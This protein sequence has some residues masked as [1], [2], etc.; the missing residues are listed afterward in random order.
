[1]AGRKKDPVR[2][3]ATRNDILEKSYA[4][5]TEKTIEA[6][7]MIEI[8]KACGCG[9]TT[10]YRY[11]STKPALAVAV[12][13]RRFELLLAENQR[14]RLSAGF[15]GMTAAEVFAFYLDTFLVLYRDHRDALRFNQ[16]FNIYLRKERIDGETIGPYRELIRGITGQFHIIYEKAARD[17]TVRTDVS[18]EKA[19][20]TTL[21]LMLAA[22]TRYAVGLAYQPESEAE[23]LEELETLKRSLL[24]EYISNAECGTKRWMR[25]FLYWYHLPYTKMG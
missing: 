25:G 8:A 9:T 19:F 20:L 18:E 21:H 5:F 23:T 3:T 13:T 15:D 1:M 14:R 11:Y 10:L 22:V 12:A 17:H 2:T 6:V 4:L 7:S 16:F 24:R